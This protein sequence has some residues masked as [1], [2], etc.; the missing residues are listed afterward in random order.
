MK[1]AKMIPRGYNDKEKE[2]NSLRK[3]E[4]DDYIK[5]SLENF[6]FRSINYRYF[7][8]FFKNEEH[9]TR[10]MKTIY[11]KIIPW[12]ENRTFIELER[13]NSH[14]HII[15][16][17]SNEATYI[18]NVLKKYSEIFPDLMINDFENEDNDTD[19]NE[20]FYQISSQ[21]GV[22]LIG[23]KIGN[24]VFCLYFVDCYHL[25]YKNNN[26]NEDYKNY[27]YA[28]NPYIENIKIISFN[29]CIENCEECLT[30]KFLDKLTK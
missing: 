22:R 18:K 8:N 12:V 20:D 17:K 21:N 11:R 23:K 27:T 7:T 15:K 26:F 13:E 24:N 16:S 25:I 14:C 3:N 9:Y 2:I 1:M 29:D 6:L 10:T 30:C 28:P 5:F 19:N 4:L